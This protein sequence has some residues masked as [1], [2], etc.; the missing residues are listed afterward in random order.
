MTRALVPADGGAALVETLA[1]LA[2]E[3]GWTAATVVTDDR[4]ERAAGLV[5]QLEYRG[6]CVTRWITVTGRSVALRRPENLVPGE[7]SSV[8]RLTNCLPAVLSH[9]EDVVSD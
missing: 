6:L 1:E 2:A 4:G 8:F 7:R 9:F 5:E 3:L